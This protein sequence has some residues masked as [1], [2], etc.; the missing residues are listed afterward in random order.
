[1]REKQIEIKQLQKQLEEKDELVLTLRGQMELLRKQV[2]MMKA[3]QGL[4]HNHSKH[5]VRQDTETQTTPS[6]A[7][8]GRNSK[9]P[10]TSSGH[11]KKG[12]S[13]FFCCV[14]SSDSS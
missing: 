11:S 7:C 10:S 9:S 12:C 5:D 3:N 1:M 13:F 14:N 2:M 4:N 6:L 8:N